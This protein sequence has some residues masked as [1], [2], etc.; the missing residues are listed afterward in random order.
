MQEGLL[1]TAELTALDFS[2]LVPVSPLFTVLRG[3][4]YRV[5]IAL[6]GELG[7]ERP[8]VYMP[9]HWFPRFHGADLCVGRGAKVIPFTS[10]SSKALKT[11]GLVLTAR[12]Q[13]LDAFRV[14]TGGA[15]GMRSTR[16]AICQVPFDCVTYT[17]L[18]VTVQTMADGLQKGQKSERL[19]HMRWLIEHIQTAIGKD[20]YNAAV[21]WDIV[22]QWAAKPKSVRENR[23]ELWRL[24]VSLRSSL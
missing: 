19:G 17:E 23:D 22:A 3:K 15:E 9:V 24:A 13:G 16:D 4:G 12:E 6:P 7:K 20:A 14:D 21:Q 2:T 5:Q 11:L 1:S 18:E 8:W 10:K